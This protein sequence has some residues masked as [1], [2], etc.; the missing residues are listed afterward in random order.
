M[1]RS[2]TQVVAE[3]EEITLRRLRLWVRNGWVLPDQGPGEPHYDELDVARV[4]LVCELKDRMNLND[5]AVPV[6]LSL[7]DQLYGMRRDFKALAQAID[8]QPKAVR[9]KVRA[10]Y[11]NLLEG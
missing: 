3:V 6:V 10:A 9:E 8:E 4:R 7:L 1:R 11:R 5:D 2:E